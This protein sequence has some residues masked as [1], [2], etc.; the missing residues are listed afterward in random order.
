M[1]NLLMSG[2][3][4]S[5]NH[6][7]MPAGRVLEYTAQPV[8]ATYCPGN[9]LDVAKVIE[10]PTLFVSETRGD[11]SQ[12]PARI[13]TLTRARLVNRDFHLDYVF[14]ADIPPISNASLTKLS[15]ELGI[16]ASRGINEF[17]RTHWAIKDVDLFKVLL[18]RGIGRRPRPKVFDL[19]DEEPD[20]DLVAIMM[21]FDAAFDPVYAALRDA[22]A[23][24]G[25]SCQR[26]DDIWIDDHVIQ[27]VVSLL[28]KAS[29][30]ICDLTSRNANVF[31]E[32]GIAHV[33]AREVIMITQN[34][35]DVPFDVAHIR[36]V[37]Y[38]R[39]NEG[40]QQLASDVQRRLETLRARR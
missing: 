35:Q 5:P 13:G 24:V 34:A 10:L 40:L 6:D 36:H 3:D 16:D 14:D 26:A 37:R 28:C 9:S 23:A 31:Y 2:A 8:L 32:M 17:S 11:N 1:F 19:S 27:D 39:N 4:W 18:K 20:E 25:M 7:T 38:L 12:G 33:L 30:V 29:L 15:G 21:P 22:V